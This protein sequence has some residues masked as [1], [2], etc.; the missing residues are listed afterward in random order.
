[1]NALSQKIMIPGPVGLLEGL[2]DEPSPEVLKDLSLERSLGTA[3]LCHPHP[4]HGGSMDNKVIQTLARAHLQAGWRVIRF[5][6]RGVGQS[7]GSY[8]ESVGEL[9]DAMS[10]IESQAPTGALCLGG[11]SFGAMIAAR[12]LKQLL[13]L[14]EIKK[15]VLVGIAVTRF[16][17]PPIDPNFHNNT[18]LIHGSED[19]TVPL[20]LVMDW[21]QPQVLPVTVVPQTGHFFHGQLPLLKGLVL[22]H[23]SSVL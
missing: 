14:R 12:V 5:N 21:A 7:E 3:V 22:R 16:E 2:I 6:F 23:L 8:G 20:K 9:E 19:D 4:L 15:A 17:V 13:G 10:V 18:L 11:F 1:M